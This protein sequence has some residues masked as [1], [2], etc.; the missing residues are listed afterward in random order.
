MLAIH[1]HMN[2]HMIVAVCLTT[3]HHNAPEPTQPTAPTYS[4]SSIPPLFPLLLCRPPP[5]HPPGQDLTGC[6]GPCVAQARRL[7][8]GACCVQ[9]GLGHMLTSH[10]TTS[11]KH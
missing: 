10:P 5:Q 11:S 8:V 2:P 3:G 4:T 1:V 9:Q 6:R 7:S